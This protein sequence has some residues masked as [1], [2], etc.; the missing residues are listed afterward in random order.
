VSKAAADLSKIVGSVTAKNDLLLTNLTPQKSPFNPWDMTIQFGVQVTADRWLRFGITT[1]DEAR[2]A[3]AR[4]AAA[5]QVF[6]LAREIPV[7]P[8]MQIVL[9]HSELIGSQKFTVHKQAPN[10]S[11]RIRLL[12]WKLNGKKQI[13]TNDAV[14]ESDHTVT[15]DFYRLNEL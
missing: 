10:L 3:L 6:I 11:H 5:P 4:T 14:P 15:L 1:L 9:N 7:A 8:E 13:T 12:I 2:T